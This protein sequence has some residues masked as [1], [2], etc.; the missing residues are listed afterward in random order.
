MATSS[1]PVRHPGNPST[2]IRSALVPARQPRQQLM[3]GLTDAWSA[4]SYLVSGVV[5]W[6]GVGMWLDARLGIRPVLTIAGALIGN[7]AGIYLV[8]RRTQWGEKVVDRAA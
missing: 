6:G 2:S 5:L 3:T 7:A 8:Y 4:V 1:E